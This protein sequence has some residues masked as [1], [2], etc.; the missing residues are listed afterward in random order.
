MRKLASLLIILLISACSSNNK[1]VDK[2]YYRFQDVTTSSYIN[3]SITVK[4]P[5]AMGI[6]GNRPMV[7][8]NTD[9][10]LLQM[11]HNFWLESPK[12]LLYQ[13]LNKIFNNNNSEPNL[14]LNSQILQLE[15]KQTSA[16][17]SIKFII[18][19]KD[20][21]VIF[22]KTYQQETKL[23]SS[24]IPDFVNNINKMLGSIVQQLVDDIP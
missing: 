22:K 17:L 13:Y 16:L 4:R 15:K 12:I 21:S 8:Q 11:N 9:G 6:I 23:A 14:I 3:K 24:S 1:T 10:A 20:N 5:S 19:D 2:L 18:T 7:V